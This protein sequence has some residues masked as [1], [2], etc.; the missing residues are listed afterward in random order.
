MY[1]LRLG[2]Q[3]VP[4]NIFFVPSRHYFFNII[5]VVSQ[6]EFPTQVDFT[7]AQ[8]KYFIPRNSENTHEFQI[9]DHHFFL[10]LE[11]MEILKNL[12]RF[13]FIQT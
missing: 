7:C 13:Q 10:S 4:I 3:G 9:V 6:G 8:C 1:S 12:S 2:L 5:S 11:L